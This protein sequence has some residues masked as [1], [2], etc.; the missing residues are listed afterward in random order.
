[1]Y[2]P[3]HL[4]TTKGEIPMKRLFFKRALALVLTLMLLIGS[5][6]AGLWRLRRV[7]TTRQAIGQHL[8]LINGLTTV[9]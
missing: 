1:M 6:L 2:Y 7:S 4:I 9:Y 5:V 3:L 8:P